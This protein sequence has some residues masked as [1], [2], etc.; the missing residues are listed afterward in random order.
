[1][2]SALENPLY[3]EI[4]VEIEREKP[5]YDFNWKAVVAWATVI[6][7][8]TVFSFR[9][10]LFNFFAGDDFAFLPLLK[11]A[12]QHPEMVYKQFYSPWMDGNHASFYRPLI[13]LSMFEEFRMWG[14]NGLYFRLTNLTC[15]LLTSLALGFIVFRIAAEN[16]PERKEANFGWAVGS[17]ALFALYPLH[18]EVVDWIVGRT[19]GFATM[20]VLFS[21]G[22]YL[23]WR[24]TNQKVAL[25]LCLAFTMLGLLSKEIAV[26][27]PP[28]CFLY[29]Y[30]W[31]SNRT[32]GD[33]PSK[34]LA[35]LTGTLPLWA[36]LIAYFGLRRL[37]LGTFVGGY[38]NSLFFI[39]NKDVF[40]SWWI[41]ALRMTVVPLN[42][43]ILGAH[44]LITKA[45]L[46]FVGTSTILLAGVAWLR[47]KDRKML[48]FFLG[49]GIL[50]LVPVY[51]I[52]AIWMGLSGSR[53]A[54]LV[55]APLCALLACGFFRLAKST[56][57]RS[58]LTAGF[59]AF[60]LLSAQVLYINNQAWAEAG[61]TLNKIVGEFN[62]FYKTVKGDPET[63]VVGL[64]AHIKGAGG[65][66]CAI[67]GMTQTP[68]IERDTH[69]CFMIDQLDKTFP[70]GYLKE[71]IWQH[72]KEYKLLW[73]DATHEK[74]VPL[75]ITASNQQSSTW[76]G[77]S[78]N[79]IL[80]AD[81]VKN[82][83]ARMTPDGIEFDGA[84]STNALPSLELALGDLPCWTTDFLRLK[85][86][87]RD[88]TGINPKSEANL[89]FENNVQP[90]YEL[91]SRMPTRF[92]N[93]TTW[94]DL[95]FGM[96]GWPLWTMGGNCH[97]L[98]LLF[99]PN[100]HFVIQEISIVHPD[101]LL[102]NLSFA[103]G[104]SLKTKGIASFSSALPA[105]LFRYDGSA[106]PK[107]AKMEFQ[108]TKPSMKFECFNDDPH[109]EV[110]AKTIPLKGTKGQ[111]VLQLPEFLS[112][113]TYEGRLA[114]L[115]SAGNYVGV[116]GDHIVLSVIK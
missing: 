75:P 55:S 43:Y 101:E 106:I 80:A 104:D 115:D 56:A 27:V 107:A 83:S 61:T 33:V 37:A 54:Y 26:T 57:L 66:F 108:I 103:N 42:G 5:Q 45:W 47:H 81:A 67:E 116:A 100:A 12:I 112:R 44:S 53:Y 95:T 7:A 99:P 4:L 82:G 76:Q 15:H 46:A 65:C 14:A 79:H 32:K 74:L 94:Q 73:W 49:W 86:R 88:L 1:V 63:L 87:L 78:M 69:N 17:A 25:G 90:Q 29:Q 21:F 18:A 23:C 28:L 97:R 22:A 58:L 51:K 8:L 6:V 2:I 40:V 16:S 31:P 84:G 109:S 60:C 68:E 52:F 92:A 36:V 110:L 34:L 13:T 71:N 91:E 102:P 85:V 70:L 89:M 20:F 30:F 105:W 38:D 114:A 64:P 113:G 77:A 98:K 93:T 96:R 24:Q 35:A 72:R 3:R 11:M 59:A 50:S 9:N 111:F 41:H 19:D 10:V 39:S 48:A 62:S